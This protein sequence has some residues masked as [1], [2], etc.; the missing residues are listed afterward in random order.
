M[1]TTAVRW[2]NFHEVKSPLLNSE[3]YTRI[4]KAIE[5]IQAHRHEQPNLATI[6]HHIH[7]S[8][9]H[10]QKLFSRWAGVSPKRFLQCLTVEYAKRQLEQ[11]RSLLELSLDAGLSSPGRLHELFVSLEAMSPG[12]YRAEGEGLEIRYGIHATPFGE[13]L[14]ATT[15]RGV[16]NLQ[17]LDADEGADAEAWLSQQWSQA[18]II[19]DHTA[20]QLICDRLHQSLAT[21]TNKPL[22]LLVKGTN[23]Q[24][25]VWRALL[26]LPL[27]SIVAYQDI[28][29]RIG[30][31]RAV[32][33]VGTALGANPVGYFIPCHRVIRG[34]GELGG[35]RWGLA[36]KSTILGWEASQL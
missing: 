26:S 22:P 15:P 10:F 12:E 3:D 27:G 9:H 8:E 20:T 5:F 17:F 28:A 32:R 13:A 11:S 24:I 29:N 36:R 7:L 35:Y 18:H 14:I 31:P 25:Q 30:K 23:F 33:A 1:I 19:H 4:A 2:Q 21:P 6:A 34:T 16:C